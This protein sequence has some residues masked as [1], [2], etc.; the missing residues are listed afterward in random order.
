MLEL[1]L[2]GTRRYWAWIGALAGIVLI[3]AVFYFWQ[4]RFGLGLTGLSRDVSWGFYV[5]QLTFL[6]GV[7]A[8]AV[9]LVLPYYLHDYKTFGKI[10]IIGEFVAVAAICMCLLFLFV[11]LGQPARALNIFLYPTPNSVIFWD[12][13][14][15]VGYLAL[16]LVVGWNVLEAERNGTTPQGWVKPLIYLSIPWAFAIH[17]VTAFLYCGLPGRGLWLTAILA[18]RFL[19]SAFASGPAFLILLCMAL[20]RLTGFDPGAKSIRALSL[21]VTYGL[22]ANLFFLACEV[23]VVFYA[24]IPEHVDHFKYLYRGLD[25]GLALVPWMN[26]S[27][28][29]MLCAQVL[30]LIP[31]VRNRPDGLAAACVLVFA[32]IWIDKGLGLVTGGFVPNPLHEVVE[33]TPT[34]PELLISLGVYGIGGLCLTMLLKIAVS[35]KRETGM[36]SGGNPGTNRI[37][38]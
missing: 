18:P 27:L 29:A 8:S 5:A 2:S 3:G 11:D 4:L 14:V 38:K 35:V 31:S 26:I 33:Y 28:I 36:I 30:L 23:F 34:L 17:T 16:N 22:L 15:L 1:T 13:N 24:Q 21:I 25:G 20:K 12:G 37:R 19:A 6:V 32:G 9:M 7:A 10:T